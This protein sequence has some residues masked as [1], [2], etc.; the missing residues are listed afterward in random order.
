MTDVGHGPNLVADHKIANRAAQPTWY[1]EHTAGSTRGL[2]QLFSLRYSKPSARND[3][4]HTPGHGGRPVTFGRLR[5]SSA[6]KLRLVARWKIGCHRGSISSDAHS[7][8]LQHSREGRREG[9]FRGLAS[10][11]PL[12]SRQSKLY[13]HGQTETAIPGESKLPDLGHV[14][15]PA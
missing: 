13:T 1:L 10:W 11:D 7:D 8:V 14:R 15:T 2:R 6:T 4:M 12:A 5:P 9:A 3:K